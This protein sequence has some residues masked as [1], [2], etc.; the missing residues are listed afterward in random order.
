MIIAS[1]Y[2]WATHQPLI[3]AVMDVYKP[4]FVLELGAGDYSTP[5]FME[6]GVKLI[7]IESDS[8]W[9]EYLNE[10]YNICVWY[11]KV[12]D[13]ELNDCT[14]NEIA[15]IYGY[16]EKLKLPYLRPNL[17]FVDQYSC[18]RTLS[19]NALRDKFDLIIYHDSESIQTNHYDQIDFN[20]FT[21]YELKTNGPCTMLMAKEPKDITEAIK[22]YIDK[23]KNDYDKC[24]E[25]YVDTR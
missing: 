22:P 12:E 14:Y 5:V 4:Q 1:G 23:F 13:K 2:E 9:I 17:L 15:S 21:L 7:S 10:K 11:H 16:Y 20:G 24:T 19:I 8:D 6:Y 18:C 3:R 25:M